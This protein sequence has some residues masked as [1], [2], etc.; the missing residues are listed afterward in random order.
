MMTISRRR[1]GWGLALALIAQLALVG[2]AARPASAEP[3]Q[4][5]VLAG[6]CFWGMEAVFGDLKGVKEAM[7]GYSG[8]AA[9]TAHYEMVSTGMTGHAESVRVTYDPAQISLAQILNV[10]FTVAHDPTEL[11]RQGPDDGT[12]YR[13]AIFVA[14]ADQ[15]AAAKAEIDRLTVE[16]RFSAPIVTKLETFK[17]FYPAEAYHRHYA[18]LHPDDMYIVINDAPKVAALKKTYPQLVAQK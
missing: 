15:R 13:S 18:A 17:A 3:A 1:F 4:T 11:N 12:Q 6:G 5:I 7:P 14:N 10:Y 16:H 8:G 9:S 2:G